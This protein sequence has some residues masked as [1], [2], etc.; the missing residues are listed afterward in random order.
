MPAFA[1]VVRPDRW[2]VLILE[3]DMAVGDTDA[4]KDVVV[5]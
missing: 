3:T 5:G 2:E 1:P 4:G